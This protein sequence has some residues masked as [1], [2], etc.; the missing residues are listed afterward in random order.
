[1]CPQNH[2]IGLLLLFLIWKECSVVLNGRERTNN[3]HYNDRI[4]KPPTLSSRVGLRGDQY[5]N[6]EMDACNDQQ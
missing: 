1:M 2:K 3:L 6:E 4:H 5:L